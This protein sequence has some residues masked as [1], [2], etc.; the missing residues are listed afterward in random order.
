MENLDYKRLS[1]L[2]EQGHSIDHEPSI[3]PDEWQMLNYKIRFSQGELLDLELQLSSFAKNISS[4]LLK[5]EA[6]FL[7]AQIYYEK[8]ISSSVNLYLEKAKAN[9]QHITDEYFLLKTTIFHHLVDACL[10]DFQSGRLS[11]YSYELYNKKYFDLI[12]LIKKHHAIKEME[13]A[14]FTKAYYLLEDFIEN[15]HARN[16]YIFIDDIYQLVAINA[17]V[18]GDHQS[19]RKYSSIGKKQEY[20]GKIFDN[21][22]SGRKPKLSSSSPLGKVRWPLQMVKQGSILYKTVAI[23]K[24]G[25]C[26]RDELIQKIWAPRSPCSSYIDR[27]HSNIKILRKIY[28]Q[29]VRYD[30]EHYTL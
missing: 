24:A 20:Y 27:L 8:G 19:A 25:P 7:I 11:I 2:I 13:N 3:K 28:G 30:G 12:K 6:Y 16:P 15:V 21:L 17:L 23:L 4:V 5:G 26:S 29:Q 22:L 18:C 9:F 14:H 1:Q 10:E